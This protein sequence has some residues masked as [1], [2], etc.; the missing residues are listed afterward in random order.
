M[1]TFKLNNQ[2]GYTFIEVLLSLGLLSIVMFAF[3]GGFISLKGSSRDSLVL[4]SSERQVDDIA[5]NI[6][7]SIENYQVNFNYKTGKETALTLDNLPMAW[8]I[9]VLST[10]AECPDCAG[11][12]GYI[13]QPLEQFRGLYQVTL[14]MTHKSWAVKGE[15]YRDYVFV[16]SAK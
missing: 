9:G 6:K 11:T 13:I 16:V 3:I 4:S 7:A 12:Y 14:R 5:E 8:D 10:R 1:K 15:K 2:S